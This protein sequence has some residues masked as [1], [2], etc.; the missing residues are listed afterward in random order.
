MIGWILT[1]FCGSSNVSLEVLSIKCGDLYMLSHLSKEITR[2]K[3]GVAASWIH[4]KYCLRLD[5]CTIPVSMRSASTVYI[6]SAGSGCNS[7][8]LE[9]LEKILLLGF[10]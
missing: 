4:E 8:I 5:F 7:F 9:C 2:P 6:S 1:S 3:L 10:S